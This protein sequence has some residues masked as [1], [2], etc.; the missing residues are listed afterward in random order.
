MWCVVKGITSI[1][2]K[3][4]EYKVKDGMIEVPADEYAKIANCP[5][6]RPATSDE[7]IELEKA[8]AENKVAS[9]KEQLEAKAKKEAEDA[10]KA[11]KLEADQ[12]NAAE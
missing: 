2:I 12:G 7:I 8:I 10:K 11:K 9:E 4:I 3:G 1:S 6:V 5:G